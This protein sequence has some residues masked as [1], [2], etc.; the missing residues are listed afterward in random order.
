MIFG[1]LGEGVYLVPF[2]KIQIIGYDD[3]TS[4]VF[5]ELCGFHVTTRQ[6]QLF[7]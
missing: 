4:V 1:D 5:I 2:F 3:L 7:K 6:S